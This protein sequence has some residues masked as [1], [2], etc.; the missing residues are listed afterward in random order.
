MNLD[1]LA[2]ALCNS[3]QKKQDYDYVVIENKIISKPSKKLTAKSV[4]NSIRK[5]FL[6]KKTVSLKSLR[7]KHNGISPSCLCNYMREVKDDL[8]KDGY[9]F[10]K[11]GV[12]SYRIS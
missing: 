11:E 3:K 10:T 8:M 2:P 5:Q 4:K 7:K 12:G 6:S 9:S 1:E